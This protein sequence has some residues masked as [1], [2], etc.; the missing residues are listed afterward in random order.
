ML[1]RD[2]RGSLNESMKTLTKIKGRG[3]LI[4]H[5][6]KSWPFTVTTMLDLRKIEIKP[7]HTKPDTRIGWE[8][9]WIVTLPGFGVLGFTNGGL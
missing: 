2:H 9:T 5:L 7:Y 1:Y 4:A 3:D 6:Q 8:E